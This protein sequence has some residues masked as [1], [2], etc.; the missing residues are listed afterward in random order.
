MK[1]KTRVF[2]S[3]EADS[4][5]KY[6][7]RVYRGGE[8]IMEEGFHDK[9]TAFNRKDELIKEARENGGLN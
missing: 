6:W 5:Y 7:V 1:N 9:D 3:I 2:L 4:E 8:L